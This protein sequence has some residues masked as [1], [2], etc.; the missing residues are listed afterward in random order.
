[1]AIT[2]TKEFYVH[3]I[4]PQAQVSDLLRA[5]NAGDLSPENVQKIVQLQISRT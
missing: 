3:I 1:M 5:I 4:N 2:Y